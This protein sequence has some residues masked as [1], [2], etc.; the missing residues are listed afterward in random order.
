M[1]NLKYR[2]KLRKLYAEQRRVDKEYQKEAQEK[3]GEERQ[4][5]LSLAAWEY[6]NSQEE[7]DQV[8]HDRIQEDARYYDI[9]LPKFSEDSEYWEKQHQMSNRHVLTTLGR[10]LTREKIR[11][12]KKENRDSWISILQIIATIC[13]LLVAAL[14]IYVRRFP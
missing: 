12:V 10:E 9:A 3:K 4:A 13:S 2:A 8:L 11:K 5:H 1:F 14:A 6:A 7:I